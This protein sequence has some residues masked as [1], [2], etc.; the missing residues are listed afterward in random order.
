MRFL[1]HPLSG[2]A[3]LSLEGEAYRYVARVRRAKE[4]EALT[5]RTL[6]DDLLH[7]YRIVSIDR[8]H[9]HLSLETSETSPVI[10]PRPLHIG[11]AVVDPKSVERSLPMLNELGV[12]KLTFVYTRFSQHQYRVDFERLERILVSSCQ[13]CG[14]SRLMV[15]EQAGDLETFLRANPQAVALDF[16]GEPLECGPDADTVLIGPEG[17]F[18]LNER[19]MLKGYRVAGLATPLILK[20]ETAAVAVAARLLL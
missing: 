5:L 12:G 16:G 20:S 7:H 4:G 14:R 6:N 3:S 2:A 19:E 15:L 17:G 18:D 8:R 13:Q 9:I 10:P 1:H 11:W